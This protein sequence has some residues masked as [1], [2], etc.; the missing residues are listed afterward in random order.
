M[1]KSDLNMACL[2]K[3]FPNNS[4]LNMS[5]QRGRGDDY[6]AEH[7]R[8]MLESGGFLLTEDGGYVMLETPVKTK[9]KRKTRKL[10]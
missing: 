5:M 8:L 9:V 4:A 1:N 3:A 10:K 7:G 6:Y 2:C